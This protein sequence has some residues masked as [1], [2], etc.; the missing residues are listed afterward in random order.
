MGM[1]RKPIAD[2]DFSFGFFPNVR[3]T[4]TAVVLLTGP[5]K[6]TTYFYDWVKVSEQPEFDALKLSYHLTVLHNRHLENDSKFQQ[7]AGDVLREILSAPDYKIG[8]QTFNN[9]NGNKSAENNTSS[10]L[11]E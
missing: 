5:F 8:K 9:L 6:G 11:V 1:K 2:I 3:G 7:Y 4:D 10:I